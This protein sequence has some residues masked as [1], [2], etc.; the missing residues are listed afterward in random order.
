[1]EKTAAQPGAAWAFEDPFRGFA[2]DPPD[3]LRCARQAIV[4]LSLVALGATALWL[5]LPS[6]AFDPMALLPA[7]VAAQVV[8]AMAV[9]AWLVGAPPSADEAFDR[10]ESGERA[11]GVVSP[12]AGKDANASALPA[13]PMRRYAP[14]AESPAAEV[15]AQ[16]SAVSSA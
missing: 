1:M 15:F 2:D 6:L 13:R 9:A 8:A 3:R 12:E 14:L 4:Y 5:Q 16:A 10:P 11:V 7:I